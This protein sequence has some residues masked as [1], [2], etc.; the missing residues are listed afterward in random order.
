MQGFTPKDASYIFGGLHTVFLHIF[1]NK[2]LE[3]GVPT[4]IVAEVVFMHLRTS[5]WSLEDVYR[6]I[7]A[8]IRDPFIIGKQIIKDKTVLDRTFMFAYP[9]YVVTL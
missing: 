3:A 2:V 4:I 5:L 7:A 6:E 9:L 8:M 1:F